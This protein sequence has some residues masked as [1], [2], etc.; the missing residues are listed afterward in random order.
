M[1]GAGERIY[2]LAEWNAL[3]P[4]VPHTFLAFHE[5]LAIWP[6]NYR[7]RERM[8]ALMSATPG[9]D[10][11]LVSGVVTFALRHDPYSPTLLVYE[12]VSAINR[13]DRPAADA[14]LVRLEMVAVDEEGRVALRE[15]RRVRD[16]IW[17][18]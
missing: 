12:I 5:A 16:E 2:G 11:S 6:L 1:M 10:P 15:L 7:M 17:P 9:L 3:R 13:E 8:A 4:Q 14:A 18:D